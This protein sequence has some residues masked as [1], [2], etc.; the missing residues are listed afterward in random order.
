MVK[1]SIC[2]QSCNGKI[3]INDSRYSMHDNCVICPKCFDLWS[4]GKDEDLIVLIKESL[5]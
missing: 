1:C 2:S 4:T 5:K 3:K